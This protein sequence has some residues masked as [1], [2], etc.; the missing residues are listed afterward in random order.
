VVITPDDAP[1]DQLAPLLA[2]GREPGAVCLVV[3]QFEEIWTS[4]L[5]TGEREA[6]LAALLDLLV[7][8]IAARVVVVVRGDHLGRLAEAP[9][10]AE[11]ATA[12]LMLVPPMTEAEVR[13][14]VEGPATATGL[15]VQPDLTDA[16][17]REVSGQAGILPLLSS[18]L[19]GTWERRRGRTLTLAGFLE[20]GGVAGALASIAEKAFGALDAAGQ[21]A[22]RPFL[23]RL[24]AEGEGGSVVRRRV[25]LAELGLDGEAGSVRR[26]V[27]EAFVAERLLTVDA[28]HVEVTHEAV[29]VAWPRLV[30][31]LAEDATG[32]AVRAH[33]AP[34]A[35]AWQAD[36]R[37]DDGLY[38]GARLDAAQEWLA[39]P[40]SDPTGEEAEFVRASVAR[41][42]AQL[43]EVRAR[44]ERERAGRRRVR[45]LAIVLA[46]T[47][48][49]ALG[50]GVLAFSRQREADANARRA[51]AERLAAA[52]ANAPGVDVAML[53]A[54]QAYRTEA[55]PQTRDAL[56]SA[57]L[58]HRQVLDV[59]RQDGV[60]NI[61]LS[62]DGRTLY[63]QDT[64]ELL[65]WDLAA[66]RHE[67]KRVGRG[68]GGV[69][70]AVASI[71]V[72]PLRGGPDRGLIA[73]LASAK[74]N[75]P[76]SVHLVEPDGSVRWTLSEKDLGGSPISVR[77][78]PG[79]DRV[80][81]ESAF[82]LST[83]HPTHGAVLADVRTGQVRASPVAS[84][85]P[86]DLTGVADF[87][88]SSL[89]P[90]G[91]TLT[92]SNLETLSVSNVDSGA[93]TVLDAPGRAT[94]TE[95]VFPIIGGT[96]S[97]AQTGTFYWYPTGS[98]SP[99]QQ[100]AGHTSDILTVATDST[101]KVMVSGGT[102]RRVVVSDL[103]PNEGWR[104]RTTL[105]GH[106]AT[107]VGL[108]VVPDGSR[109]FSASE[110]GTVIQ[111]DLSGR[112]GF[113]EWSPVLPNPAHDRGQLTIGT[114]VTA[115]TGGKEVWV[116]PTLQGMASADATRIRLNAFFIDPATRLPLGAP[117]QLTPSV[118]PALSFTNLQPSASP[119]GG[120][121]AVP[122]L[123][124]TAVIDVGS[125]GVRRLPSPQLPGT[126]TPDLVAACAWSLDGA[127]LFLGTGGGDELDFSHGAV[128]LVDTETWRPV[129][130]R[131]DLGAAVTALRASP[132]RR[133]LAAGLASGQVVIL[134][135]GSG[136]VLRRLTA[137]GQ[138][139]DLAFSPDGRAVAA[140][141]TASVLD[142]WNPTTGR[143]LLDPPPRF[144]GQGISVQWLPDGRTL[145][146][147]G[148]DGRAVLFDV[149]RGVPGGIPMPLFTDSS[150]GEV[151]VAPVTGRAVALMSG[152]RDGQTPK[153]RRTYSLDPVDWLA[154][155]CTVVGRD[156]TRAEW[157]RY[158]PGT[159]WRRTCDLRT[160][161]A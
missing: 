77:F 128:V 130:R 118:H 112:A 52:S 105:I 138:V 142:L 32:R 43:T 23:L 80:V 14:V 113:G 82:G 20:A 115:R 72:S 134:D 147:G 94:G 30:A 97:A 152:V 58:A 129:G 51:D 108:V 13:E 101:G 24:A 2:P 64:H 22:A 67:P 42:Q 90:G 25:P 15:T 49:V 132:D 88:G 151:Y 157:D 160:P 140:V 143:R 122:A 156:L 5:P 127:R 98:V 53:L 66:P 19:V 50:A 56:L 16:V 48:V 131:V 61:A 133:L 8:E 76:A 159:P 62:A 34:A 37:P 117:V 146:Y 63:G 11:V 71:D 153:E 68:L 109:A 84:A 120:Q 3:D 116:A 81:V 7:D 1:V 104:T 33:L 54:A 121:V 85:F 35:A 57:A 39:R 69:A 83:G 110:D 145:V 78:T 123:W 6:F 75:T 12:G 136:A 149:E 21:E 10:L 137:A 95:S 126:S 91:R 89:S 59:F 144:T 38:R 60:R 141:G 70:G 161:A 139:R 103:I 27:L 102:D 79:G 17:L 41:S 44:A 28:E 154:F 65:A 148:R 4:G 55:T 74:L 87:T 93:R 36:G 125:R 73:V 155:A 40:D 119:D 114:P 47:A 9:D 99:A 135:Q 45:R 124:S 18:A 100:F 106:Q 92:S 158:L 96:L 111:W 31:W 29:F 86:E 150:N 107:I 46:A 26:R